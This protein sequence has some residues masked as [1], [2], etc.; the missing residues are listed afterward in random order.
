M[1]V[2]DIESG[3]LDAPSFRQ[4]ARYTAQPVADAVRPDL[5]VSALRL[6]TVAEAVWIESRHDRTV[7]SR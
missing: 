5:P 1:I 7:P 3:R 4:P 6:M 2:F